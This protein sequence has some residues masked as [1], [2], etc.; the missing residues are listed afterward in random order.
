MGEKWQ[1]VPLAKAHLEQMHQIEYLCF[2]Q[3]WSLSALAEELH[4]PLAIYF[5]CQQGEQVLGYI[6][7]RIVYDEC[8]IT[9]VAVHPDARR[10]GVASALLAAL[11]QTGQ[12]EGW[13]FAT[14]EVRDSNGAAVALYEKFGFTLQ[15]RRPGYYE[16]PTEDALL[17]TL[18]FTRK[19]RNEC[20]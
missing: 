4:N 17:M 19:E 1:I 15:G 5:I 6:G 12:Q 13:I 11:L 20:P 18:Y 16:E 10:Q 8:H 3:P 14:L 2:S 9:N 7:T